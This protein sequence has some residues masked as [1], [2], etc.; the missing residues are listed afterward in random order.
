MSH[1]DVCH[2]LCGY[3]LYTNA[4]TAQMVEPVKCNFILTAGDRVGV[5]KGTG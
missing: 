1:R 5:G 2:K 3:W 4:C